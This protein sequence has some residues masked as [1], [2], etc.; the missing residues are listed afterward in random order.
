MKVSEILKEDFDYSQYIP[1][2]KKLITDTFYETLRDEDYDDPKSKVNAFFY[3]LQDK[4]DDHVMKPLLKANPIVINQVPIRFLTVSF[5]PSFDGQVGKMSLGSMSALTQKA[6]RQRYPGQPLPQAGAK[7]VAQYIKSHT[8]F[9][10]EADF[11]FNSETKNALINI[12]IHGS[13]VAN[14]LFN[15]DE[16]QIA[17]ASLKT[18]TSGITGKLFHEVKHFIQNTKVAKN[19]GYNAQVNKFFTGPANA[20]AQQKNKHY[21]NTKSG[22]WLNTDEM[23]AWA[24]NAAAE[25][26]NAFGGDKPAMNQYMNNVSAGHTTTHNGVPVSTSM[27]HYRREIFNPRY[28]MN[29]DRQTVWRRFVKDVYKDLQLHGAHK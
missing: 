12:G 23:D 15:V 18:L 29:T 6:M 17:D 3:S 5:K 28:N 19:M 25:I 11:H 26:S 7:T 27:D 20:T 1:V 8:D 16:Q 4:I 24:A 2:L 21:T 10:G 13:E 22:Y 14:Y 9:T